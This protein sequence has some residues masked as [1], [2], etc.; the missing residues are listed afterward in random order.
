MNEKS[1]SIYIFIKATITL[2][3]VFVIFQIPCHGPIAWFV[4][5]TLFQGKWEYVL[6]I[7]P[8]DCHVSPG[9]AGMSFGFFLSTVCNTSMDAIKLSIGS[10]FPHMLLCGIIWPLEGMPRRWMMTVAR[11]FPHTEAVQGMRGGQ[12]WLASH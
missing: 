1:L 11:I 8:S 7:F 9:L 12:G 2:I 10:C 3:T 4:V 5:L 6:S